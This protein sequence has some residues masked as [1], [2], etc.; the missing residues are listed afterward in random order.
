MNIKFIKKY[1]LIFLLLVLL[2]PLFSCDERI[3]YNPPT[4]DEIENFKRVEGTHTIIDED[5]SS[6]VVIRNKPSKNGILTS[7]TL[8]MDFAKGER[9]NR[10]YKYYQFD[11][12]DK[13]DKFGYDY[14]IFDSIDGQIR[15][16]G[17]NFMPY[18]HLENLI[19]Y[20]Q[21][22]IKYKYEMYNKET[23]Q[24]DLFE[25]EINICENIIEFG[26]KDDYQD[27]SSEYEIIITDNTITKEDFYRYQVTIRKI[28]DGIGHFDMQCYVEL[29]DGNII[30]Y[31]GIYHYNLD[32]KK[33]QSVSDEEL[34]KEYKIKNFYFRIIENNLNNNNVEYTYKIAN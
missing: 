16:Y 6:Y 30:P 31:L 8:Y 29:E 32:Y 12:Y 23:H 20:F 9:T 3:K 33:F 10:L 22:Q 4:P 26:N 25:K 15:K 24:K 11:Y 5:V 17:Q 21:Y 13:N 1:L 18:Y 34:S 19:K 7:I 28:N 14:H 2:T 27:K